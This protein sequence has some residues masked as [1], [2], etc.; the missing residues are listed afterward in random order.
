[1]AYSKCRPLR[2]NL[3]I[4]RA[5][6]ETK[7][8]HII[9]PDSVQ[10]PADRGIV[11]AAGPGLTNPDGTR[12][13][14]AVAVGETVLIPGHMGHAVKIDDVEHTLISDDLVAAVEETL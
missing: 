3:L 6:R 5:P 10:K 12:Q 2:N 4:R 8:G 13:P 7:A 11:V 9:I 14:T 1:M